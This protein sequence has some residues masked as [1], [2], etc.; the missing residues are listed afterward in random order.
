MRILLNLVYLLVIVL[1]SPWLV[2]AAMRHGKYREGFAEK[3]LGLVPSRNG[4][5]PCVWLHAVSVGEVNLLSTMLA[6]IHEKHPDWQCVI[7]TTTKTGMAV[8]KK[9]YPEYS[10]FYCPLDFSWAV[11][12]AMRRIRPS[13][14]L[15]AELELWPNMI[16][17]AKDHGAHVAVFNGRLSEN[18]FRGYARIRWLVG[19]LL[20][21]MD[22]IAVQDQQYHD[23]FIALGARAE[24]VHVTGSLKY[25]GAETDRKNLKTQQLAALAGFDDDDLVFLAGSTQE[26]EE[27]LALHAYRELAEQHP[28]LRLVLVP[29]H[30]ERFEAVAD[31]LDES[32]IVWQRRSLLDQTTA[33]AAARVLLVDTVGELSAWWGTA[34]IAFVGGSMGERGGQNMIEPAAFGASVCFGPNTH[35]FRDVV[36]NLMHKGAAVVVRDQ[37]QLTQF[38]Q[39]SIESP[40]FATNLGQRAQQFVLS[41]L[42]ATQ[43]TWAAIEEHCPIPHIDHESAGDS[44]EHLARSAA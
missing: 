32:G 3:L 4:D 36:E 21:K 29:R 39:R 43:R 42:G 17:A 44:H 28:H 34:K 22:L 9:N 26:S 8:A 6:E 1:A 13:L 18:S 2:Y 38:V 33:N 41:Q 7:S 19:P 25:D 30:P 37:Q 15:L 12:R 40:A 20:R 16:H 31:L 5:Q 35:N 24:T 27:Q 23:R 14:L 10:V 11:R